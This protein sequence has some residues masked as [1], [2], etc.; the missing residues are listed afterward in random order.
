MNEKTGWVGCGTGGGAGI[1]T[2]QFFQTD[3]GGQTWQMIAET[4]SLGGKQG[5]MPLS[6][7]QSGLFFLDVNHGWLGDAKGGL[8]VT[9]DGGYSWQ[10]LPRMGD[11][12]VLSNIRFFTA[13]DGVLVLTQHYQ[14][15]STLLATKDGGK[16]WTAVYPLAPVDPPSAKLVDGRSGSRWGRG[17]SRPPC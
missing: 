1:Q 11:H 14:R 8:M 7:Y 3:D 13:E 10:H 17:P 16:S 6:S 5:N 2:K 4:G 15:R 12:S 9:H